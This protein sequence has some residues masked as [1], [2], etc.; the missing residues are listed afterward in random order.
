MA[1][2]EWYTMPQF[3][4]GQLYYEKRHEFVVALESWDGNQVKMRLIADRF[5]YGPPANMTRCMMNFYRRF[6]PFPCARC[7]SLTH[8]AAACPVVE[9]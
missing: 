2:K 9:V 1:R 6:R 4:V 3:E 7:Q 8:L 5:H